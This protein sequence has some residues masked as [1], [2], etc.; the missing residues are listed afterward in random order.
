[1]PAYSCL[2][3]PYNESAF[4]GRVTVWE[5]DQWSMLCKR[6]NLSEEFAVL[7]TSSLVT[8]KAKTNSGVMQVG[9]W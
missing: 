5:L 8:G 1:M 7:K 6:R 9:S 2:E 4:V 3:P